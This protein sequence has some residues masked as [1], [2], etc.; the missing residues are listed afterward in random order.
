[1]FNFRSTSFRSESNTGTITIEKPGPASDGS[2]ADCELATPENKPVRDKC[3]LDS[4]TCTYIIKGGCL[5]PGFHTLWDNTMT[6][7]DVDI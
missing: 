5:A 3:F 6:N 7:D 2:P 1:M 4:D